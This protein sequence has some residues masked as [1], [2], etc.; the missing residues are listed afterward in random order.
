MTQPADSA[1]AAPAARNLFVFV[2]FG[3]LAVAITIVA[4]LPVVLSADPT[5]AGPAVAPD[6]PLR[7]PRALALGLAAVSRFGPAVAA[8]IV[9]GSFGR[10]GDGRAFL[11]R[12][13]R[14]RVNPAWYLA[15]LA[16]P[17]ALG[18]LAV[19]LESV[20]AGRPGLVWW[21]TPSATAV[22]AAIVLALGQELGWRGYGVALLQPRF[23]GFGTGLVLGVFW[24]ACQRWTL[25]TPGGRFLI[26]FFGM[27]MLFVLLLAASVLITWLYNSAGGSLPVA[28]AGGAGFLLMTTVVQFNFLAY[29][30]LVGVSCVAAALI[31]ALNGP[32]QEKIRTTMLPW[33]TGPLGGGA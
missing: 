7:V 27:V 29:A 12:L 14:W 16:G 6:H 26:V 21:Q 13:I 24:F 10:A 32:N 31:V 11:A 2:T 17:F 15:A 5:L 4:G 9:L 23:G 8:L 33:T 3:V 30:F 18:L 28:C 20:L 19:A 25:I 1:P 22:A